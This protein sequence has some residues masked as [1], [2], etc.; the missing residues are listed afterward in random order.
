MSTWHAKAEQA[1]KDGYPTRNRRQRL[2]DRHP[3]RLAPGR[4]ARLRR[5]ASAPAPS[6]I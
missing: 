2:L 4:P 1:I 6:P 3:G 5:I